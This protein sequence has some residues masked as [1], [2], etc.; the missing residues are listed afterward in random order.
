M[1]F[2]GVL[3]RRWLQSRR[4]INVIV[5][6]ETLRRDIEAMGFKFISIESFVEAG[7]VQEAS[8][9]AEE[10]SRLTLPDGSR[11]AELFTYKGYELWWIYY[12][13]LFLYFCLPW[14]QYKKL[15]E[16]LKDFESIY[17]YQPPY[18]S[19]FFCYL[20]AY[21]CE[22]SVLHEPGFKSPSFLPFGIFLQIII[23]LL[24][25]PILMVKR[26]GL[27]VFVGD[28]FAKS[29]DYDFR[30]KFIYEELRQRKIPFVEFIRSLESWKK[31]LS[32][33]FIVRRRP[34]IYSEAIAFFGRFLCFLSG[35]SGRAK[36]Q[37]GSHLFM[38]EPVERRFKLMVATQYLL[39]VYDDVWA[40]RIM[41][42]ILRAI[43]FKTAFITAAA[44][45]NF[46]AFLG[47]KL[48]AIPTVGILHGVASRH[49]TVYD[50]LPGF[51]G[52]KRM[53]VDKYG[54]WSEWWKKY[55]LENSKGYLPEQLY[56]SALFSPL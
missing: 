30:M 24:C 5:A 34:V 44:E 3:P 17:L 10:L 55:Y 23:T 35:G 33:A 48:N 28:K 46:H 41:K 15:L 18:K 36:H 22:A 47:C 26:Y 50:F 45:R 54:L 16:Y 8:T 14:T 19:L 7:S 1:V 29:K 52:A 43:G 53:S 51:R 4:T 39:N 31:V 9:F 38:G 6:K 11:L 21:G 25:L 20:K 32:H 37:F 12:T 27:M 40:I 2:A 49:Y 13:S 42:W 56:F